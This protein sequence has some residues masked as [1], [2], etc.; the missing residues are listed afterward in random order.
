[1]DQTH[2]QI[3][4]SGAVQRLVEERVPPVQDGFLQS[5]LDDVIVDWAIDES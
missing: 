2:E 1:V 3:V 5:T 4:G